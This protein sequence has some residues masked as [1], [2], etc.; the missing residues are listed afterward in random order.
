MICDVFPGPDHDDVIQEVFV[1]AWQR[2]D[3]FDPATEDAMAWIMTLAHRHAVDQARK[4]TSLPSAGGGE[5]PG[6]SA[7]HTDTG[8]MSALC[9]TERESLMMAYGAGMTY[10]KV[11]ESLGVTERTAKGRIRDGVRSLHHNHNGNAQ[12]KR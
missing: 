5:T 8:T 4:A 12:D 3:Q 11:A 7:A 10:Q 6:T 9:P 2:A 1:L